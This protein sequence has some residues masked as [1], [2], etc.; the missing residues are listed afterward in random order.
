ME[1]K[2]PPVDLKDHVVICNCNKKVGSIIDELQAE[3]TDP[4]IDTVLMVQDNALWERHTDWHPRA[5]GP[6]RLFLVAG[7][8]TN[9]HDLERTRL[10]QA[11]AAIILADP[12][13]GELVD[14]RS[15]LVAI[16]IEQQSPGVH[17]IMEL[18][19]SVTVRQLGAAKVNEVVC[20]GEIA[21]QLIAQDCITPGVKNIF[22]D[23]LQVAR[24]TN[25]LYILPLPADQQGTTFGELARSTIRRGA[26]HILC[27]F[28]QA[29]SPS[30]KER[31]A[32]HLYVINPRAG[33]EPGKDTRL[34]QGDRLLLM[35]RMPP[36]LS[37]DC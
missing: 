8:T 10:S 32:D 28:I 31:G 22:E 20:L 9:K 36:D 16:A 11:R 13:Q 3:P 30:A 33:E 1:W 35:A 2:D 6:G 25:Q 26:P 12:A 34:K 18:L 21:E 5:S 19:S 27:G 24:G 7:C 14:A 29:P 15:T 37:E 17:T 23:L 4:P